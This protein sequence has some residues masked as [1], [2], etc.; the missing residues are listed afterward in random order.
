MELLQAHTDGHQD[1]PPL[2]VDL[3]PHAD[4]TGITGADGLSGGAF[5]LWGN[6]YPADELPTAGTAVV[7]GLP[8][9]FPLGPPGEPDNV[10]CAGQ[11]IELPP[12]RYD[13][14]QL[15]AAAERRTEDQVLLHYADGSVDPEWLRVSDFW[16]ETASRF[17]GVPA[18][19]CTRLH[20]P[21]HVERKFGPTLWR[22]R[23]PVPRESPLAA[24][25]LPDNPAVHVFAMTLVPA[26]PGPRAQEVPS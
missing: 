14:I 26:R 12:G 21:R 1:A 8:F 24:I 17:G 18:Y 19:T 2:P 3:A 11:L 5:N 22:H 25:R 15:L 13:W 6:T 10:R 16:P 7:D 23:V 4:N 9:R 20:Y